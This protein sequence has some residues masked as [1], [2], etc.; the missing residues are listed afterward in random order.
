MVN[1]RAMLIISAILN[2]GCSSAITWAIGYTM[3][4]QQVDQVAGS[5]V[6]ATSKHLREY[7]LKALLYPA[8]FAIRHA[9]SVQE[10]LLGIPSPLRRPSYLRQMEAIMLAPGAEGLNAVFCSNLDGTAFFGVERRPPGHP[11][12]ELAAILVEG[13]PYAFSKFEYGPKWELKQPALETWRTPYNASE[14]VWFTR[15]LETRAQAWTDV[16]PALRDGTLD[17]YSQWLTV[18]IPLLSAD[19]EVMGVCGADLEVQGVETFLQEQKL[20][21]GTLAFIITRGGAMVASSS[22][23]QVQVVSRDGRPIQAA[24]SA[25]GLVRA[26]VAQSLPETTDTAVAR[27]TYGGNTYFMARSVVGMQGELAWLLH[28]AMPRADLLQNIYTSNIINLVINALWLALS[29]AVSIVFS[30]LITRPLVRLR[31]SMNHLVSSLA[32]LQTPAGEGANPADAV[33]SQ[34][35]LITSRLAEI[36]AIEDSLAHVSQEFVSFRN[37]LL[38]VEAAGPNGVAHGAGDLELRPQLITVMVA[39]VEDVVSAMGPGGEAEG[40]AGAR[41]GRLQQMREYLNFVAKA[42]TEHQGTVLACCDTFVAVW[43][44]PRQATGHQTMAVNAALLCKNRLD[45]LRQRGEADFKVRFALDTAE[46]FVGIVGERLGVYAAMGEAVGTAVTLSKLNQQ[47]GT[48]VL[49]SQRVFAA[50]R[51]FYLCRTVDRVSDVGMSADEI[52]RA[53]SLARPRARPSRLGPAPASFGNGGGE[54]RGEG[55]RP[56][57]ASDSETPGGGAA[58]AGAGAAGGEGRLSSE[59]CV[60]ELICGRSELEGDKDPRGTVVAK[61][62]AA[63]VRWWEADLAAAEGLLAEIT[64]LSTDQPARFLLARVREARERGPA[65]PAG[66]QASPQA[67]PAPFPSTSGRGG[68]GRRA[69]SAGKDSSS[70]VRGAEGP[71]RGEAGRYDAAGNL[72]RGAGPARSQSPHGGS[73]H[74]GEREPRPSRADSSEFGAGRRNAGRSSLTSPARIVSEGPAPSPPP[75]PETQTPPPRRHAREPDE[76]AGDGRPGERERER[77]RRGVEWGPPSFAR[78]P[79][80]DREVHAPAPRK[81]PPLET[82][83]RARRVSHTSEE[84]GVSEAAALARAASGSSDAGLLS[85]ALLPLSSAYASSPPTV[86]PWLRFPPQPPDRD[87]PSRP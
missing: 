36:C 20:S 35:K 86:S 2:V 70:P 56:A 4:T 43:N 53:A 45:A 59:E 74:S 26:C 40:G 29:I 16:Y 77:E 37:L 87:E 25:N 10:E 5:L 76:Y 33:V 83:E 73:N 11:G 57:A 81:L 28:L 42:V 1:I 69:S 71:Y 65:G 49:V 78:V 44:A 63:L 32:R 68:G 9:I 24:D 21:T 60:Y 46:C 55:G 14:R 85:P 48:Q 80:P 39:Y 17:E 64:A 84:G 79:G 47:Y 66:P 72:L 27:F 6:T 62:E 7:V 51:A 12:V 67:G 34:S 15:A 22:T 54:E 30:L 23:E 19:G 61:Y 31:A 41:E 58:G 50:V 18:S 3:S 8:S 13:P 75:R 38:A 52:V 82:T